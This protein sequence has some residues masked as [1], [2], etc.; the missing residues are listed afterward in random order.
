M[1]PLPSLAAAASL[2]VA[3]APVLAEGKADEMG[4]LVAQVEPVSV[5]NG[6]APPGKIARLTNTKSLVDEIRPD[7]QRIL[8]V[9]GT[10]LPG[11]RTPI[12]VHDYSGLTCV[13]SGQIT[14]SIEGQQDQVYESGDCYY[15]PH[16]TPMAASNRGQNPVILVD[17]FVLP[18]G[19]ETMRVIETGVGDQ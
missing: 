3:Q 9:R 8:A 1:R 6:D 7:G 10:R 12:H 11:T 14:D 2:L 4:F 17:V 18:L 13:I 15:M 16:D 5:I 19:E